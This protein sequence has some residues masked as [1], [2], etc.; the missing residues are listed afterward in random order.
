MLS[1][2][3]NP[4]QFLC[5][6]TPI[7]DAEGNPTYVPTSFVTAAGETVDRIACTFPPAWDANNY[8]EVPAT[9]PQVGGM[10][11]TACRR[12]Q[13]SPPRDC[14]FTAGPMP[15]CTAGQP[16]TLH[17]TLPPGA[18]PQVLR[19]CETSAVLGTG[20]DCF[21]RAALANVVLED[22]A[23]VSLTC[24]TA[25]DAGEPGGSIALYAA[26]AYG[27]DATAMPTCTVE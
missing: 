6:G 7:L 21:Y 18:A 25:R 24:P 26:P 3:S 27:G 14:G 8:A 17:C 20:V 13:L 22:D 4:D 10:V 23:T 15:A 12:G 5:E 11:T 1:F 2:D 16:T 19:V 9:L